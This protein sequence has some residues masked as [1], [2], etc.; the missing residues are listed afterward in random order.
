MLA[1]LACL[2]THP[3]ATFLL[4]GDELIMNPIVSSRPRSVQHAT[5]A[6]RATSVAMLVFTVLLGVVPDSKIIAQEAPAPK[7]F[8][9]HVLPLL[10]ANCIACHNI[11]KAEGGL[12]LE[13]LENL[14]KGGD[15]GPSLVVGKGAESEILRRVQ[16]TDES[17]MPPEKNAVGAKRL[18]PEEIAMISAW[19]DAGAIAGTA[20]PTASM[21]W[22]QVPDSV[23]P[24]YALDATTDGQFVVAGRGNQA[25]VYR[26]PAIDAGANAFPLVDPTVQSQLQTQLPVTHLDLIQSIAISP[27]GMRVATGGFR[28]IKIWKRNVGPI[29]DGIVAPLRGAHLLAT[30]PNSLMIAKATRAPTLEVVRID[31]SATSHQLEC[32]S[33]VTGVAWSADNTRLTVSTEDA[34]VHVFAIE[35]NETGT[36]ITIKPIFSQKLEQ[37]LRGIVIPDAQSFVGITAEKK[38]QWWSISVATPEA[39][40]VATKVER[41]GDVADIVA[42]ARYDE[43]NT[44]R[45]AVATGDG[46]VRIVIAADGA[47]PRTINHGSPLVQVVTS[48][49]N[50][51]LASVGADGSVKAWNTADGNMLWEQKIDFDTQ[52]KMDFAEVMAARQKSKVD[53]AT[54]KVPELEKAKQ[55]EMDAQGKLQTSRNQI[56]EELAKKQTELE[57]NN[58]MVADGEAAMVAAKAAIEE[59]MKKAEQAQKDLE[60][61][62][63]QQLA[64]QKAKADVEAKLMTMDKTIAGATQ[65]IE[66][67]AANLS[68]FQ[69]SIEKEKQRLTELEQVAAQ[70]K[71]AVPNV[72]ATLVAFTADNKGVITSHADGSLHLV[73]SDKGIQ[74]TVLTGGVPNFNTLAMT[75][76][77]WILGGAEDGR[78]IAWDW[79]NR[80]SLERSI[81]N[82]N[83]SPFSDRITAMDWSEDGQTLVAGSGAPS[84][85]GELKLIRVAD[86]AIIKDWGQVHSDTI[87]VARFSPDGT[88]VATGGADKLLRLH[89]VDSD[90]PV[91]TLEGHTHHVLGVAWHDDGHL[92]ASSSADNTIKVWDVES[93]TATRTIPG[94]G[95]EVTALAFV[96]RTNQIVS[97]SADQQTRVHDVTNGGLVRAIG[98]PS[99]AV[100]CAV[101][102]GKT[103]V[104]F[105]GGQDGVLWIWQLD[106]GQPLQQIK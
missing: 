81:G 7:D 46:N 28:D 85:F 22:K 105:A 103:P 14:M 57:A 42:L 23:R 63:T 11:Q 61:K 47:I 92:L 79:G 29:E 106:N 65:A 82:A 73:R 8:A 1:K 86:G 70:T 54:A 102:A 39:P 98:G 37:P 27:D 44:P 48:S 68:Q 16:A 87:L 24:M 62:K 99:D 75:A 100:Y 80:W 52:R 32:P 10:R 69:A 96:G 36:P 67:A 84:R 91:R 6:P 13:S 94:F 25:T 19:V 93:G 66:R 104:A 9:N 30:S 34:S 58:K 3:P 101:V 41:L 35:P 40:A 20:K 78:V 2:P 49:D 53:R 5:I 43:A 55:A 83:D 90:A 71:A 21:Q 64:A 97:S 26:W 89:R 59:A 12:N 95:K 76:T 56:N 72:P 60:A 38:L 17:M 33:I 15:S 77:G 45:V 4:T 31:R 50:T 88:M 18:T 51:K 74:Q